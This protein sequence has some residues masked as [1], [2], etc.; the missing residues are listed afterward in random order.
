LA[1]L[2][3]QQ[4]DAGNITA[5]LQGHDQAA[6]IFHKYAAEIPCLYKVMQPTEQIGLAYFFVKAEQLWIKPLLF[7]A[8]LQNQI[9]KILNNTDKQLQ[10]PQA[11]ASTPNDEF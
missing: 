3:L 10:H 8:K 6:N 7:S 4:P 1:Q 2:K 5:L 11:T 9:G